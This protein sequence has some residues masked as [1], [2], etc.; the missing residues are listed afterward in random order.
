MSS[1][2]GGVMLAIKSVFKSTQL[3]APDN[4]EVVSVSV[5]AHHNFTICA[6]YIPPSSKSNCIQD[7]YLYLSTLVSSANVILLG[8]FN[9]PDRN[10][11]TYT[12]TNTNI[13][14]NILDLV[15]TTAQKC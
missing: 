4:L 12:Y 5:L 2:G 13:H 6:I 10:W 8:D 9:A 11:D 15:I 7:L 14:G 1:N 3:I